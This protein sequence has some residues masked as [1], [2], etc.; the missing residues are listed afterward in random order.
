[1]RSKRI[2]V[3]LSFVCVLALVLSIPSNLVAGERGHR[4]VNASNAADNSGNG[5][6]LQGTWL[7]EMLYPQPDNPDFILKF[8]ATYIGTGDNEGTEIVEWINYPVPLDISAATARGVW[9]KSGPNKYDY[10]MIGFISLKETGTILQVL[11]HNGTKTLTSCNTMT[12][13]DVIQYLDPDTMEPI[14]PP[15]DM[16]SSGMG[17]RIVLQKL[18]E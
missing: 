5:C 11:Q 6:K 9:A 1:M 15:I 18:S 3:L 8:W 16:G 14:S 17:H 12:A 2:I 7:W 4:N 13:T 10:T